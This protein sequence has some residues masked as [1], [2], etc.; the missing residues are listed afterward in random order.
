M[1]GCMWN[2][3]WTDVSLCNRLIWMSKASQT[4]KF[5]HLSIIFGLCLNIYVYIE[6]RRSHV[7]SNQ[8]HRFAIQRSQTRTAYMDTIAHK[9]HIGYS[10][11]WMFVRYFIGIG[12]HFDTDTDTHTHTLMIRF[13]RACQWM[14][15]HY[16]SIKLNST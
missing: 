15:K 10:E 9:Q 7:Q 11:L 13:T 2:L 14:H 1:C 16:S 6:I 12:H 8:R 5:N 4:T 3:I